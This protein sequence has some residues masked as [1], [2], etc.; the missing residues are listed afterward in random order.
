MIEIS[1][2]QYFALFVATFALVGFLTPV[3][4]KVAIKNGIID[5]PTHA[6]KTHDNFIPYLGGVAIII[7]I[8]LLIAGLVELVIAFQLRTL[9]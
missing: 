8:D 1:S 5:H 7:G 2:N 9:R 4:R 6:H 3:M